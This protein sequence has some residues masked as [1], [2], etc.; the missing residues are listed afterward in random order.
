MKPFEFVETQPN[1]T[2]YFKIHIPTEMKL[3]FI[4]LGSGHVDYLTKPDGSVVWIK[5]I[6]RWRSEKLP[7][8]PLV[9][10]SL[11]SHTQL[12]WILSAPSSSKSDEVFDRCAIKNVFSMLLWNCFNSG[13]MKEQT[14]PIDQLD[15]VQQLFTIW[16]NMSSTYS[17]KFSLTL[18]LTHL[19]L[20]TSADTWNLIDSYGFI[21]FY[22][23]FNF[24]LI[25]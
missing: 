4:K 13:R 12:S 15:Y 16:F 22:L 5:V 18:N 20:N 17:F 25:N 3:P 2:N 7:I 11:N 24:S 6:G 9:L 23:D 21:T 19:H 1:S 8:F 10:R 14:I